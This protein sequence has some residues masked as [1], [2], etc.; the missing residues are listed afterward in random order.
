M[1]NAATTIQGA[2]KRYKARK[3]LKDQQPKFKADYTDEEFKT[4]EIKKLKQLQQ[5]KNK[6]EIEHTLFNALKTKYT[7]VALNNQTQI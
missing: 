4:K 5:K 2:I 3:T 1:N 6:S 7:G